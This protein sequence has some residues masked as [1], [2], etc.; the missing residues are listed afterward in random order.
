VI[1]HVDGKGRVERLGPQ[2]QRG[3][4]GLYHRWGMRGQHRSRRVET[5]D[6]PLQIRR[7]RRS[8][9]AFAAADVE[10]PPGA[11]ACHH[12]GEVGIQAGDNQVLPGHP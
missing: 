8:Q 11:L 6:T 1:E 9:R 3:R 7:Q 12:L 4:V 5:H 2:R 10:D